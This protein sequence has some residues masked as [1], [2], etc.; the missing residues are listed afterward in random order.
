MASVLLHS[1]G[2]TYAAAQ[3]PLSPMEPATATDSSYNWAGYV[4]G[5]GTYSAV[6]ANWIVP[7]V[8]SMGSSLAAD[9]TWVGIG[10]VESEDLIQVGTQTIAG[11]GGSVHYEAWWETLPEVSEH[12]NL[13]VSPGDSVSASLVYLGNNMWRVSLIDNTTNK[14]AQI[15]VPYHSSLS[16]AE[17]VEEMPAMEEGNSLIPLDDFGTMGFWGACTVK[18]GTSMSP[19]EAGA[20]PLQ[21]LNRHGDVLAAPSVLGDAGSFTV[22]RTVASAQRPHPERIIFRQY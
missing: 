17:W 14:E 13:D 18:D 19:G 3:V 10:G 6:F 15:T 9:A 20:R 21:M 5:S 1:G 22:T 11:S 16:S 7:R 2:S 12:L 8:D 4:A